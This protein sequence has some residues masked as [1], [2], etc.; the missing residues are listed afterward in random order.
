MV[1]VQLRTLM[2]WVKKFRENGLSGLK[3]NHGGGAQP[4]VPIKDHKLFRDAVLKLQSERQGGRIREQDVA[5]LIQK[6]YGITPSKSSVYDT[7][8]RIGLVWITS[9]SR[10]P[11]AD[12]EAQEAFKKTSKKM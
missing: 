12:K 10:H 2:N 1:R 4:H 7:L 11:K 6:M 5:S 8:K 9:R 3:D